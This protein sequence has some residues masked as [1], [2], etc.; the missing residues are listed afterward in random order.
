VIYVDLATL[1]FLRG[2]GQQPELAT[3]DRR[4]AQVA[5]SG[6]FTVVEP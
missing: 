1:D 3:Y 5:R 4:Q 2:L 6:G